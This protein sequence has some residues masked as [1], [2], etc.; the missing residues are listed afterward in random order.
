MDH[1]IPLSRGGRH[2]IDNVIPACK[3]C[4]S[5]KHIRTEDEFRAFLRQ[6]RERG[7]GEA[8]APDGKPADGASADIRV[9]DQDIA[10]PLLDDRAA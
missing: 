8:E 3:P 5:R 1:R 9:E 6:E 10:V 2:E 7:I 4:N